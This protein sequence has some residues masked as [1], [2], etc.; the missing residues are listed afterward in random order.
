MSGSFGEGKIRVLVRSCHET[1]VGVKM[2]VLEFKSLPGETAETLSGYLPF[3][4]HQNNLKENVV[5]FCAVNCNTN[6]GGMERQ[7]RNNVFFKVNENLKKDIIG[8]GC[9]THIVRNCI[10]HAV[11]TLPICIESLV[12]KI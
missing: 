9:A 7:G 3:V 2:K 11:D 4:L 8:I 6:F 1:D 10:Q 5:G 12:V